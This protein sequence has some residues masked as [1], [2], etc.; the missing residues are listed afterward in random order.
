MAEHFYESVIKRIP[1]GYVYQQFVCS[2]DGLPQDFRV[3]ETN[4]ALELILGLNQK[5]L[6]GKGQST[7]GPIFK[8][9]FPDWMTIAGCVAC[10]GVPETVTRQIR[11]SGRWYKLT[12]Y[13]PE[14]YAAITLV[15]DISPSMNQF[16]EMDV[17][18]NLS[19][20]LLC[21]T[22]KN[23]RFIKV[24]DTWIKV[25]GYS[26][27]ELLAMSTSS[28]AHPD[29][30]AANLS[31]A[32]ALQA[33]PVA[34]YTNRMR[35]KDGFYHVIEWSGQKDKENTYYVAR[36]VSLRRKNEKNMVD[37]KERLRLT[38]LSVG[39][40]VITLNA[41]GNVEMLNA[42]AE[43]LTG[44]PLAEAV[45][46]HYEEVFMVIDE[47]GEPNRADLLQKALIEGS[48][49]RFENRQ[50]L[51]TRHGDHI[52]IEYNVSPIMVGSGQYSGF[53]LVCRDISE[54]KAQQA[55]IEYLNYH[56]TLTGLYNRRFL[57]EEM[58][59]L[60]V[61]RNLPMAIIMGDINLLKLVNDTF[62][63]E[64]G[65]EL[66]KEAALAIKS[67]CR[68]EDLAARWGGDEFILFLPRTTKAD[69]NI[70]VNRIRERC[71]KAFV[72]GINISISFGSDAKTEKE[73]D[74]S[75]IMRRAED[76]MAEDKL[77]K[78]DDVRTN[79]F[80]AIMDTLFSAYPDE[81]R[82]ARRVSELCQKTAEALGY[83]QEM[84]KKIALSGLIHDIG[85]AA[86]SNSTRELVDIARAILA[87]H[88]RWEGQGYPKGIQ[89]DEIPEIA[90][91]ISLADSYDTMT[92]ETVY[93]TAMGQAEAIAEI[94]RNEGTQYDP[95]IAEIFIKVLRETR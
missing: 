28:L 64:K 88:G 30:S 41:E 23:G 6:V 87:H 46:R 29:D 93:W 2:P 61:P 37:N 52:A 50:L 22:D 76:A 63:Q 70:V 59:R 95:I 86:V 38:L 72:N 92:N 15:S 5:D 1:I 55:E 62:G 17:F 35:D 39:D 19:P 47:D 14:K 25:L 71:T 74:I 43:N 82:H 40:G 9:C 84:V 58:N 45:G 78:S 60:D 66:I 53:V 68:A 89:L 26:R 83:D 49:V 36:D 16:S 10:S 85:E 91:I 21:I 90:R 56:D 8:S 11:T 12:V 94:R 3:L 20:E 79:I 80:H 13:S 42:A 27:D 75:N 7:L 32:A 24:N 4:I 77:Q 31:F 73:E 69:A 44:W 65:D 57:E 54:K 18:F 33:A 48:A 51:V 34:N 67:G 81:E